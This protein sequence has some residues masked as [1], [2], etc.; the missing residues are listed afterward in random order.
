PRCWPN[1]ASSPTRQTWQPS[2]RR[3]AAS[4]PPAVTTGPSASI[5]AFPPSRSNAAPD[6]KK[7]PFPGGKGIL[8]FCD[9]GG[10][11]VLHIQ[12]LRAGQAAHAQPA[13]DAVGAAHV[14]NAD[15]VVLAGGQAVEGGAGAVA[16]GGK[17]D[18]VAV[19]IGAAA[20][21]LLPQGHQ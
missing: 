17:L 15:L 3:R 16:A 10:L 2:P 7:I 18:G 19:H 13:A 5:T 14:G 1:S 21:G 6:H 9:S 20:F 11:G 4:W 12:G 8:I